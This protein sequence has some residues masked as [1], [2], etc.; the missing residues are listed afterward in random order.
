MRGYILLISYLYPPIWEA[1]S[2]R[3]YYLSKELLNNGFKV[4]VVTVNTF[5]E[6]FIDIPI[7]TFRIYPG[8]YE[9]ILFKFKNKFKLEKGKDLRESSIFRIL[10]KIYRASRIIGNSLLLGDVRL[11]W[12]LNFIFFYYI[13]LKKEIKKYDYIIISHEPLVDTLIG[14]FLKHMH[15]EIKLIA[16]ISDP[17]TADYYPKFWRPILKKLEY[18]ILQLSDIVI[19]TTEEIKRDYVKNYNI[20]KEKIIVIFQGYDEEEIRY[21]EQT[22]PIS[23]VN[24]E[25]GLK[26]FYAG[27]FYHFRNPSNFFEAL[28]EIPGLRFYYAGRNIEYI[29]KDLLKNG[30]IIYLGVL[31]HRKV[32]EMALNMDVVV[33]IA[34]KNSTHLSGKIFEYIGLKKPILCIVY[35]ENDWISQL[36]K[37]YNLGIVS[38]NSK[39]EIKDSLKYLLN[40]KMKGVLNEKFCTNS[41]SEIYENFSWKT[42]I[43]KLVDRL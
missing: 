10:K 42:Q 6:Y 37:K 22:K 14:L 7:N 19:V 1:Q 3:W 25:D 23:E 15:P 31:P 38:L 35:N 9:A 40:L 27:S 36:V 5:E 24:D 21:L 8:P 39:K 43:K 26:L 16:D 12:F 29:P 41:R 4:D 11:E 2:I 20:P 28:R 17:I 34:N 32:L 13:K 33:Y 30:K 18:K